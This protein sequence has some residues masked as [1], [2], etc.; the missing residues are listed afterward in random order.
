MS[1]EEQA[2]ATDVS[3]ASAAGGLALRGAGLLMLRQGLVSL[4]TLAGVLTLSALL[5]PSDFALYGY[6]TTVMLVAAAVGDL[7]LGASLIRGEQLKAEHLR[8]SFALQLCFWIP[9]C[10]VGFAAGSALAIYGFSTA[11]V[12]L[13]F[14]ALL[15]LSLQ[16]LP[17]ALLERQMRFGSI[18][19]VEVVQRV[20]FVGVAVALAATSPTQ[21]SIPLAT[22]VAAAISYPTVLI[23]S[24]WR[25]WPKLHRGEPLFRGFSSDW[26]QSKIANQLTYAAYPLLGGLLFSSREVGLMV[27]ALAVT[28]IPALM[29]PMVA[30]AAFPAMSRTAPDHQVAV[31]RPL[32]KGLLLVGLPMVA[33]LLTCAHPL[34]EYVLGSKWLEGVVLLRLESITTLLGL[35]L[36]AVAPLLFLVLPTRRV[37]WIMVGWTTAVIALGILLAPI[38]SFRSISIGQIVAATVVLAIV[39]RLLRAERSYSLL[40]DMRPGLAGLVAAAAVGFPLASIVGSAAGALAAAAAVAVVQLAVTVALGG[41]ADPR[42]I[43]RKARGASPSD[44]LGATE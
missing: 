35:V 10:L 17:T 1:S 39:E 21:W 9:A 43:L 44:A 36:T 23:L 6:A 27:W 30:R 28:S 37:K 15:L 11:T 4:A 22:M 2:A 26:W 41:G 42:L 12:A 19:T 31:F 25:W 32:L 38:A 29:S 24:R 7:G 16:A 34:T 33:A 18:T 14:G 40:A 13:L 20:L 5:D 8:G 3:T